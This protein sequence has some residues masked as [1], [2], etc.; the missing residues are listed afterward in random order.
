MAAKTRDERKR[1]LQ[2]MSANSLADLCKKCKKLQAATSAA[3][4]L[5]VGAMIE[6]ILRDEYPAK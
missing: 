2:R 5:T 1:E 3:T 6:E 4:G